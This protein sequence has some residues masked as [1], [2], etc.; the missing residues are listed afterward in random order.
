MGGSSLGE[1]AEI[2]MGQSPPGEDV[3][4]G[5]RRSP[6]FEWTD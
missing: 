3:Q 4:H 5:R 1:N 2:V 6:T